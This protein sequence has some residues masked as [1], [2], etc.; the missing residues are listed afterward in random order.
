MPK[1]E[2]EPWLNTLLKTCSLRNSRILNKN[3]IDEDSNSECKFIFPLTHIYN[4]EYILQRFGINM[5]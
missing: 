3:A 5:E 4:G 2:K 1:F